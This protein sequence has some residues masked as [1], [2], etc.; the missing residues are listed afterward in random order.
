MLRSAL[1]DPES[2]FT[3]SYQPRVN[4]VDGKI[5][6]VEALI[7]WNQEKSGN[8]SPS[9]FIPL[10]EN[11]GLIE[12]IDEWVIEASCKKMADWTVIDPNIRIGINISGRSFN[13]Q[14]FVNNVIEKMLKK[15]HLDGKNFEIEITEGILIDNMEQ[16]RNQLVK[17]K[18]LGITIAIDDF[19]TGFSS[20]S[21]LNTLP[22]DTL[23]IDGRFM[24][25]DE[26]QHSDQT[27][28]KAIVALGKAL[29]LK[30]VAECIETESQR[31]YLKSLDCHEGQGFLW[32]QP[33]TEWMPLDNKKMKSL[34]SLSLSR[35][36]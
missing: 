19:G 23:K 3:L 31:K 29:E 28:L 17:L 33:S 16:V 20:L 24:C 18:I 36:R 2:N 11:L 13:R 25:D 30:V 5:H 7:R 22:I 6:S 35:N 26:S 8:I 21:Y 12:Q 10:A 34:F 9:V 32:G 15:Y 27:V 1:H 14:D 4:L